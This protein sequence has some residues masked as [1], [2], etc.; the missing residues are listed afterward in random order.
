YTCFPRLKTRRQ[1]RAA[2]TSGGEQQMCAIGRA[3]M[4]NPKLVLLDEPSMGLAP[5]LVDEVFAIVRQ[6]NCELGVSFLVAEQSSRVAPRLVAHARDVGGQRG[7]RAAAFA[8]LAMSEGEIAV[9]VFAQRVARR[10]AGRALFE[11][12]QH[13]V[14]HVLDGARQQLVLRLEM[15]VEA[16]V[17]E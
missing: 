11:G 5:Q 8:P 12:G 1:S 2:H 4:A 6:L 14:E 17:R 10:L 15:R 16:A 9:H 13:L 7:D 3:L